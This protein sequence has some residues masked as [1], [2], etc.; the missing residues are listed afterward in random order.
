MNT[1]EFFKEKLDN[2]ISHSVRAQ[3]W[4]QEPSFE[5]D[6]LEFENFD[7]HCGISR[8]CIVSKD[9]NY[10][11]KFTHTE[12]RRGDP[13]DRE[14]TYYENAV[15]SNIEMYFV[16]PKYIG[17]YT[18]RGNGYWARRVFRDISYIDFS[19]NSDEDIMEKIQEEDLDTIEPI[20]IRLELYE[21]PKVEEAKL[22]YYTPSKELQNMVRKSGS[23]FAERNTNVAAYFV[24]KYGYEEFTRLADFLEWNEINDLHSGNIGYLGKRLVFIDYAGYYDPEGDYVTD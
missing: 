7:V 19:A 10:V 12:D 3:L 15:D 5:G 20:S 16:E 13:C 11:V 14:C 2:E 8:A 6:Y 17:T 22:G 1:F 4:F 23:N 21:Y 18:W 24:E 9:W